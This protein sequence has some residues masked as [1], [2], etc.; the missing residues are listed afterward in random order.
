[1]FPLGP[2]CSALINQGL[3]RYLPEIL[4]TLVDWQNG[5]SR[6]CL[7]SCWPIVQ[8]LPLLK[9]HLCDLQSKVNVQAEVELQTDEQHRLE[10]L[11]RTLAP[12]RKGPFSLY[13]IEIEA[14]WRSDWKWQRL[15]PH[16]SSLADR[17]VL[18]VG[19]SNGYFLWRM[20]GAGARLALGVDPHPRA[21]C[22]FEAVRKL[23][24]GVQQAQLMPLGLEQLPPTGAFDALFSMGVI[25]H[26]RS[27]L[28]H[29]QQ[30]KEQLRRGG[31]LILESLV[32]DGDDQ[33]VLL[34]QRRYAQ[35]N[36]V[37]FIPSAAALERWLAR[38]GFKSI[39]LVDQTITTTD[40]QRQTSWSPYHSLNHFLDPTNATKTI[41]GY[42]APTRAIFIAQAR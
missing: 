10:F 24:G 41:E 26:R 42:P 18:D 20:V 35:M 6:S 9:P 22:Q 12:W 21:L 29:L 32:I 7:A 33:H 37:F 38:S 13:G 2:L 8:Q 28:D 5:R 30:L 16:I 34:P 14:E 39:R 23:L 15:L 19:C 11:L 36:N 17:L 3:E 1:M 27:P 40:E 25:Y 31:E 4:P